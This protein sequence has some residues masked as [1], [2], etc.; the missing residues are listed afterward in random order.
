[1]KNTVIITFLI[2]CFG[3]CQSDDNSSNSNQAKFRGTWSNSF[4]DLFHDGAPYEGDNFIVYSD[5]SS[6]EW[7]KTIAELAEI[8]LKDVKEIFGVK[9][10][11]FDFVSTQPEQK[12][13]ILTNYDQW[14]IALAYRDGIIMRSKDGPNFFGDHDLWQKVFQH[15]ITHVVEFLLIG[16][17][18]FRQSNSVWFREG[19]ANYGARNHGVQTVQQLEEWKLSNEKVD[20]KGNPISIIKWGDFPSSVTENGTT[21]SYYEFFELSV[22][23][24]VDSE[25]GNGT[26]IAN[27]VDFYED[28]GKGISL[29][30]AFEDNYGMTLDSYEENWWKLMENY[31]SD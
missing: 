21:G 28:L 11:D 6:Q 15:E 19:V 17:P 7:R 14:N 31:L 3:A 22:R 20:G 27:V 16:D 30:K 29:R 13:H 23:Y 5:K 25:K 18:R 8:S 1:M 2:I 4:P 10:A 24:L 26:T 12:I 9:E